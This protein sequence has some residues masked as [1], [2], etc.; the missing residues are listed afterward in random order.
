[1]MNRKLC[2]DA[3]ELE[4]YMYEEVLYDRRAYPTPKEYPVLVIWCEEY[5]LEYGRIMQYD[6]VYRSEFPNEE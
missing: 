4:K 1:M 6:Y 5:E 3:H 2:R